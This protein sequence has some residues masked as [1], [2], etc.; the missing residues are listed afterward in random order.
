MFWEYKRTSWNERSAE[1]V[2]SWQRPKTTF[3]HAT[4]GNSTWKHICVYMRCPLKTNLCSLPCT[5]SFSGLHEVCC[6][7]FP[8]SFSIFPRNRHSSKLCC[9]LLASG[10]LLLSLGN[11]LPC[12][13]KS[14]IS[15]KSHGGT[16]IKVDKQIGHNARSNYLWYQMGPETDTGH[17]E[18]KIIAIL[19]LK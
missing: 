2:M 11:H 12:S 18:R 15:Y 8:D 6:Y 9:C 5:S 17:W 13:N 1:T 4:T 7:R 3:W 19:V 10:I 16:T 14:S